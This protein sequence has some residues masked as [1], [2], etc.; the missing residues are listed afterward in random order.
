MV[1]LSPFSTARQKKGELYSISCS[2]QN[3]NNNPRLQ[4][5][6][7]PI[8]PDDNLLK[9][10]PGKALVKL[11]KLRI[12]LLDELVQLVDTLDLLVTLLVLVYFFERG[13]Q[14]LLYNKTRLV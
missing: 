6:R 3:L 9:P 1:I 8:V 10:P 2:N 5:H 14:V 4:L 11:G 13:C 7:K 12:L